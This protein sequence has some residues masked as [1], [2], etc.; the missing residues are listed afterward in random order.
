[1]IPG[2]AQGINP[3]FSGC[4]QR[5]NDLRKDYASMLLIM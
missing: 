1:M 4:V 2:Q 3:P 5:K